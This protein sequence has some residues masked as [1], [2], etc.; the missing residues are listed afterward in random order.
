MLHSYVMGIRNRIKDSNKYF[1]VAMIDIER[2]PMIDAR[3][4]PINAPEVR[5]F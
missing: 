1:L 2:A 5:F 4:M 3:Y